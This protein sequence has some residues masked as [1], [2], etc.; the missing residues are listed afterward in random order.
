MIGASAR[1]A[2][3]ADERKKEGRKLDFYPR[4]FF[5]FLLLPS[6]S[7]PS[8]EIAV[9]VTGLNGEQERVSAELCGRSRLLAPFR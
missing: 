4:V 8:T 1:L 2:N 6:S 9:G 3:R 7:S 5:F